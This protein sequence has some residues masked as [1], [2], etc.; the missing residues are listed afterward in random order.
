[1]RGREANAFLRSIECR[2]ELVGTI[3]LSSLGYVHKAKGTQ[4][5]TRVRFNT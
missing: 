5:I 3:F 1:M 2:N 4:K